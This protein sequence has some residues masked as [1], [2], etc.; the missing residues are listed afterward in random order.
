MSDDYSLIGQRLP[1]IDSPAKVTG[2]AKYAA[3][4]CLPRM[5]S[6]KVLRSPHPHARILNIDLS[7][8]KKVSGVV[9]IVTGADTTGD[10]WGVFRYTRDQELLPSQKVRYVG[11]EVAAV[12]AEDEDAALEAI[13][14]I[15]VDYEVLPAVF[16]PLEA[17]KE[18]APL[19]HEDHPRNINIHVPINVG[20]V[21]AGFKA[22][23]LV[24]EDTFTSEAESYFMAEPLAVVASA[25]S[26]G[27]LEAWFPNAAPHQKAKALSNALGLP[28]NKI[29]VRK[30]AQGGAFGGRSD[31]FPGEFITCLL[32]LRNQRPVKL[33]YTREENTI[34]TRQGH[35]MVVTIKTGV[36]KDGLV[37]ARDITAY[38]DGGAYSSTGPI[39]TSVPF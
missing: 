35:S 36:D 13:E 4:L 29:H 17:I 28:M 14:L 39:A 23:R 22:S 26:A 27:N 20:D 19:L 25:D 2:E 11:D 1:R 16:D 10:K 32:A 8:A 34:A 12:A 3:D 30:I 21:E 15:D 38:M 37:T 31:V 24:R 7:R 5:L 33:V 9:D 18:G 6:C